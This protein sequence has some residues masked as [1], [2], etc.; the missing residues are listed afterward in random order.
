MVFVSLDERCFTVHC[1]LHPGIRFS[2]SSGKTCFPPPLN[3]I[4]SQSKTKQFYKVLGLKWELA[5]GKSDWRYPF[6]LCGSIY[7]TDDVRH[8]LS[9]RCD[10]NNGNVSKESTFTNPN[11]LEVFG[12]AIFWR[13][14]S[15]WKRYDSILCLA[16]PVLTVVTV[17]QVQTTYEVPIYNHSSA[18]SIGSVDYMNRSLLRIIKL[19]ELDMT[20]DE[21]INYDLTR[22]SN[23]DYLSVHIGD[24]FFQQRKMVSAIEKPIATA[25]VSAIMS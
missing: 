10:P 13:E 21:S 16:Q 22:Y 5:V 9:Y 20:I 7:R 2:H 12:N 19:S 15:L 23:K 14:S 18:L 17:N 1:K 6:D 8:V 25:K 3:C 24:L 4:T 11:N